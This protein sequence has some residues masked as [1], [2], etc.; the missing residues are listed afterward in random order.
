MPS[1]NVDFEGFSVFGQ[2]SLLFIANINN[3][4]LINGNLGPESDVIFHEIGHS[5]LILMALKLQEFLL[6][7]SPP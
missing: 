3:Y 1:K 2:F 7:L 5:G 4:I 6:D